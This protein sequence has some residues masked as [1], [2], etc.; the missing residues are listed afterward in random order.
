MQFSDFGSVYGRGCRPPQP[1]PVLARMRQAGLGTFPQNLPF[2]LGEDG[3]QASHSSTGGRSQVQRLGQRYE[4]DSQMLQFLERR[5]QICDG[6]APA[7]QSPDQHQVDFPATGGF[8]QFLAGFSF[9]RA[10]VYL[11]DLQS[12]RPAAP[13]GILPHGPV[14]HR[15]RLLI[16]RRDTGIQAS[17][18]HFRRFPCLAKNVTGFCLR[19]GLF[20]GHF[21]VWIHHIT[22][23]PA[24]RAAPASHDSSRASTQTG[25]V[26][27]RRR[28]SA[29]GSDSRTDWLRSARRYGSGS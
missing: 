17:T 3:Q 15:Q 10:R 2:E 9:R 1:F 27:V 14:L 21:R 5:Q 13:R 26:S 11:A 7:I 24:W 16:I 20:G 29:T 4:T 22:R 18:K 19:K 25:F 28:A 8:Q 23:L 6:P 12:N